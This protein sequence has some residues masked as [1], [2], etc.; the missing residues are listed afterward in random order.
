MR[1]SFFPLAVV[2]AFAAVTPASAANVVFSGTRSNVDT[3]GLPS[4]RC[5]AR[6][7]ASIRNDPP[8]ATASGTSNFGN[9]TPTMSHCIT[10]PLSATMTNVFDLGEFVFQFGNGTLFGTY[11]G[12]IDFVS[13]GNFAIAQSHVVTGGT[14]FF[15]GT[16]GSFKSAGQLTFPMGRP[17]INQRF[18]GVLS[19]PGVPEPATWGMLIFGF[20]VIG[21]ALRSR[22]HV[23]VRFAP[24]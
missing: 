13:P 24:A 15:N 12:V 10:L 3:P 7:T 2:A 1:I 11:Q 21:S 5:G 18:E 23:A 17:T 20:G 4:A 22:R 8:A 6:L 9:F 14:G 19:V 16:T